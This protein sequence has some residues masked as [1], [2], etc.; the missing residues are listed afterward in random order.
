MRTTI[1][2]SN[3][4]RA[5]LL[6]IAARRGEKGF[7]RIVQEAIDH[8][9]EREASRADRIEAALSLQGVLSEREADQFRASISRLRDRWR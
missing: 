1:E 5:R 9:L 3:E 6:D 8:Y 2:L 4:Q 7:S